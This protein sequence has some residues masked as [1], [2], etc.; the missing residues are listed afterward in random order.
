[1]RRGIWVIFKVARIRR[2]VDSGDNGSLHTTVV[3]IVPVDTF[4]KRMGF[5]SGRTARYV[6]QSFRWIG[7]AEQRDDILSCPRHV[8]W[9][10]QTTLNDLLVN[11]HWVL[12]PERWLS[13]QELINHDP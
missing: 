9:E 3:E 2:V 8:L 12:V 1:I 6:P 10:S 13:N 5:Y 4:K 11:S 7:F